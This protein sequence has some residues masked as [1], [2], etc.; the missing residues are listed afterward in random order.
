MARTQRKSGTLDLERPRRSRRTDYR[1]PALWNCWGYEGACKRINGQIVVDPLEYATACLEWVH[2]QS[3]HR[4]DYAGKSLSQILTAARPGTGSTRSRRGGRPGDWIGRQIIY[5]MMIRTSTAWD[6][7]GDGCLRNAEA[8]PGGYQEL[9]TFLKS[10]LLMPLLKKMGMTVLYLLPVVK[11]SKLYRK[12]ELGCPYSAKNCLELDAG[13]HDSLCGDD[14]SRVADEFAVFVECAHR[15]GMRVMLDIAPRTAARDCDWIL[16]HPDWFYWIDGK[17]EATYRSPALPEI[18]YGNPIIG[19]LHEIYQASAVR[20]HLARFR[21][22]PNLT[23]PREWKD[24]AARARSNPPADLMSAIRERFGVVTPPG[25]SDVINDLQPPW[26][27]VTY[28]RLY[29]D[30]PPESTALLEDPQRQ[31]PYV[32][33]DTIKCNLFPGRKPN[34]ELWDRLAGIIPF[35]Q[36]FGIDGARVDMAHALPRELE[37]MILQRPRKLDPDFS[38]IAEDLG[39]H[40]HARHRKAGYNLVLGSA[41]YMEP[42]AGE[43]LAHKLLADLPRL[44]LP[45]LGA[46]ET[47]DSP[48]TTVRKGGRAFSR[49]AAVVNMFLPNAVPMITSGMEVFERQPMN[50]GLDVGE[51]GRFALPKSDPQYGKLAFFDPY[52]L[53]WTH[54]EGESMVELIARASELRRQYLKSISRPAR[55]FAP[56]LGVNRSLVLA[57][58][59]AIPGPH[60]ALLM[61]ANVD[62]DRPR[63]TSVIDL[64]HPHQPEVLL[65]LVPSAPPRV[66]HG[67]LLLTLPPGDVKVLRV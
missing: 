40:H 26:S 22:A 39:Y 23:H 63:R 60:K 16:E 45:I 14:P 53:H 9:G 8:R 5:A 54:R 55:Y 67:R 1:L 34:R 61:L 47:P 15:L 28:F 38:F 57:G 56:T 41:Y 58:G 48:R 36:G 44:S 20:E 11:V 10:V 27:D 4:L 3:D 37:G 24:F 19:R 6:H 33:F 49:W 62:F 50:L 30:H 25:F 51:P 42:R 52:A 46:A 21:F 43:G 12:G 59:F 31:P 13:Q 29:L 64:P 35:Y 17:Y 32:L 66:V 2:S 65:E 18:L 7:D